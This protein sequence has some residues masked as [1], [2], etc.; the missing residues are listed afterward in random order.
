MRVRRGDNRGIPLFYPFARM[1]AEFVATERTTG[2]LEVVP[3][4]KGHRSV[5]GI[6]G[7]QH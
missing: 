1:L 7:Q 6:Y 5:G 2:T 4:W 3:P